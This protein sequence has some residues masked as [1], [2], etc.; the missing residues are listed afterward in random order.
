MKNYL[1]KGGTMSATR[2]S[3][4]RSRRRVMQVRITDAT[5]RSSTA[6]RADASQR[7][8]FR[9]QFFETLLVVIGDIFMESH[10][11]YRDTEHAINFKGAE[12]YANLHDKIKTEND[13][14]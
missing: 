3:W 12:A 7:R 8:T 11:C 6:S 9:F 2:R 13:A 5:I 10:P 14:L 4:T 1:S